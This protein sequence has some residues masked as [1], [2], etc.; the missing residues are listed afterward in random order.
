MFLPNGDFEEFHECPD[1]LMQI[2]L[3]KHWFSAGEGTPDYFLNCGLR[4]NIRPFSGDGMIAIIP[5]SSYGVDQEYIGVKLLD[6]LKKDKVYCL[7]YSVSPDSESPE[8]INAI[9]VKFTPERPFIHYWQLDEINPDLKDKQFHQAGEWTKVK[10]KYQ[11]KGGERY[12]VVGNFT[13]SSK[14]ATQTNAPKTKM[15]WYSYYYFDDFDL[16]ESMNGSCI[17]EER[18]M[19]LSSNTVGNQLTL[20]LYF[21][22]DQYELTASHKSELV[23]FLETAVDLNTKELKIVGHTDSDGSEMYNAILSRN[24]VESASSFVNSNSQLQMVKLWKG[25]G[26][27]V[28]NNLTE[29]GK[30][31]NRR[32]IISVLK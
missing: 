21:D 13:E 32:V 8:L 6:S 18:E 20:I 16:F 15:S 26:E 30:A 24:R 2:D 3:A 10:L 27:P 25:E 11:A 7:Q 9:G 22:S 14:V 31:S 28:S 1:R 4:A 23:T 12:M 5:F 29:T 19:P 17:R